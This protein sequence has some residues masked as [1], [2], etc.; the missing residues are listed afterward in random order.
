M[1]ECSLGIAEGKFD[2]VEPY[3]QSKQIHIANQASPREPLMRA[4]A[5]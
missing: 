2:S 4:A 1:T 3:G 5:N